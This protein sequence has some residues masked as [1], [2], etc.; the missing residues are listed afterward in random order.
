MLEPFTQPIEGSTAAIDMAAI[1][2]GQLRDQVVEPFWISTTEVTWDAFDIFVFA[3]DQ[4]DPNQPADADVV[5]RPSKPYIPPDRGFGHQGFAAISMTRESAEAFCAWLSHKTGR[6]YRL[7]SA[8][9]WEYACLA[10][11]AMSDQEAAPCAWTSENADGTTHAVASLE[12][13][14]WGLYDMQGNAG[15]WVATAGD[16][17]MVMGGSY[18]EGADA[19]RCGAVRQQSYKWN[20]SDPQIPKS[21]WWLADAPF[22][23][24]RIVCEPDGG[25]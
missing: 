20:E 22:V 16:T 23:G 25:E 5:T 18:V 1:P 9:E 6:T 19:C 11:R 2:A 15:E 14:A 21:Q 13:N 8:I 3:L 17:R 4:P 10:G 7:P 24:F 12:P